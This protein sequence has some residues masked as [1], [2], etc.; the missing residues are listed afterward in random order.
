M[1][2][3]RNFAEITSNLPF[4]QFNYYEL[5]REAFEKSELGRMKKFFPLHEM[6]ESLGLV[7]KSMMP[8]RVRKPYFTPVGKVAR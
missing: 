7:S 4:S 5:Y 8:K 2:K 1:T 6:A 3:I